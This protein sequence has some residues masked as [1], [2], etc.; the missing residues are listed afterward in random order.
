MLC[1]NFEIQE[2]NNIY[3]KMVSVVNKHELN[4]EGVLIEFIC[5]FNALFRLPL[6]IKRIYIHNKNYLLHKIYKSQ[7]YLKRILCVETSIQAK[8][9]VCTWLFVFTQNKGTFKKVDD[10][11]RGIIWFW[12]EIRKVNVQSKANWELMWSHKNPK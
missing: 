2:S 10:L 7:K 5:K 4:D 8:A 3:K 9:T 12:I 6:F 1:E 11:G